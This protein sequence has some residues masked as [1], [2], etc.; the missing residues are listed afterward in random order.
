MTTRKD[1]N[2]SKPDC[3]LT[4]TDAAAFLA[5]SPR[6]L[7]SWRLR[8]CGPSFVRLGER[9][10]RYRRQDLQEFVAAG[11]RRSTSDTGPEAG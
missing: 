11:V 10:V 8:G 1:T 5:L 2:E 9:A 7:E 6:A 3:L 4:T